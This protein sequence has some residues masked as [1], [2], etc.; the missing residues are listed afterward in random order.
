MNAST[1]VCS[2]FLDSP[3]ACSFTP[4]HVLQS[5][6]IALRNA[7]Q[8]A[9]DQVREDL[10]VLTNTH[11]SWN[12]SSEV[13]T[14][15]VLQARMNEQ[16]AAVARFKLLGPN[17]DDEEATKPNSVHVDAL[18]DCMSTIPLDLPTFWPMLGSD[19]E[20]GVYWDR[21]DS[22]AEL[23]IDDDGEMSLYLRDLNLDSGRIF[24]I[25]PPYSLDPT[26]VG[27]LRNHLA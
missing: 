3:L 16:R 19:G 15:E 2:R 13:V 4:Q 18:L 6:W 14:L 24:P 25:D 1:A 23:S 17:W 22:Y 26:M 11:N 5:L 10:F 20:I 27:A 9:K 21:G 7:P 12:S 8:A